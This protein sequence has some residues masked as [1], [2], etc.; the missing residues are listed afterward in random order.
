MTPRGYV[1]PCRNRYRVRVSPAR[2]RKSE[3]IPVLLSPRIFSTI[4]Q[5]F[6]TTGYYSNIVRLLLHYNIIDYL[7][8]RVAS[9]CSKRWNSCGTRAHRPR[10]HLPCLL[11]VPVAKQQLLRPLPRLLPARR[12]TTHPHYLTH[13]R[14]QYAIY[15]SIKFLSAQRMRL[16]YRILMRICVSIML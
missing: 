9:R 2:T 7:L 15:I 11:P 4:F 3:A 10:P 6:S 1:S 16:R 14:T 5:P 12:R 13:C 8:L